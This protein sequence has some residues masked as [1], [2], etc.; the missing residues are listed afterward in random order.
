ML[1]R[2]L[3]LLGSLVVAGSVWAIEPDALFGAW[4][5]VVDDA[6][7]PDCGVF[8]EVFD[9]QGEIWGLLLGLQPAS[10]VEPIY[11]GTWRVTPGERIVLDPPDAPA[12][13]S[14][15]K[16]DASGSLVIQRIE[17]GAPES[18]YYRCG[19]ADTDLIL[20]ILAAHKR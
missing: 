15:V 17:P 1:L 10:E 16:L 19:P 5:T 18:V 9:E 6:G 13:A 2:S 3:A 11:E 12:Y 7:Q 4:T 8:V 20:G 14:T